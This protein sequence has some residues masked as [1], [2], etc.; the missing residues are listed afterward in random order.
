LVLAPILTL[1]ALGLSWRE[2]LA[3]RTVD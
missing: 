2:A 3:Q 1:I